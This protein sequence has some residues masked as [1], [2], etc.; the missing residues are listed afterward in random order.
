MVAAWSSARSRSSEAPRRPSSR[1]PCPTEW[2]PL[3]R[4]GT[5]ADSLGIGWG[6]EASEL[7][8]HS[9]SGPAFV[10]PAEVR[11]S[12]SG[13][14]EVRRSEPPGRRRPSG[15]GRSTESASAR[16]SGMPAKT[17]WGDAAELVGAAAHGSRASR[18]PTRSGATVG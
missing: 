1:P 4:S 17:G 18:P 16:R 14:V 10:K 12:R 3:T 5:T 15:A 13:A 7:A 11:R 6:R 9:I 2:R 8:P